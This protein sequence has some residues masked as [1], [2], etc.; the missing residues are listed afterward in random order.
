MQKEGKKLQTH[1]FTNKSLNV[2]PFIAVLL[3]KY[4]EELIIISTAFMGKCILSLG[5]Q[6]QDEPP[7]WQV[8][9]P[10]KAQ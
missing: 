1:Y 7:L 9:P 8:L 4:P 3:C 6:R 10:V 2:D 5:S